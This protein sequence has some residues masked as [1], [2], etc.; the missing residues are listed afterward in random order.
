MLI[1]TSLTSFLSEM[2]SALC[3]SA[4]IHVPLYILEIILPQPIIYI[5]HVLLCGAY[6]R[7]NQRFPP[8]PEYIIEL[9]LRVE[10]LEST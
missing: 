10:L 6:H 9:L 8:N 1:W 4:N 2:I 7:S 3:V 5:F